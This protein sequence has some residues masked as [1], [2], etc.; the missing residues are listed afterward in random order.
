MSARAPRPTSPR[1]M[2]AL[3]GHLRLC[4]GRRR[5]QPAIA[6][7][8]QVIGHRPQNLGGQTASRDFCRRK[9]PRSTSRS[10][11]TLRSS[12]PST[13]ST[14]V[15]Q[16]E[17]PRRRALPTAGIQGDPPIA[18]TRTSRTSGV[19]SAAITGQL[20]VPHLSGWRGAP[21]PPVQRDAR[22]ATHR[23]DLARA[24]IR[25]AFVL[26]LGPSRR[27]ARPGHAAEAPS[28]RSSSRFPASSRSAESASGPPSTF[29]TPSR[30]C[31][32]RA[33][34]GQ[35]PVRARRRRLHAALR[36]RQARCEDPR[37][38]VDVYDPAEH[39]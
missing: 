15:L 26:R 12:P 25:Q 38:Q 22:P 2:P 14:F 20:T 34:P 27:G 6:T 16:R 28:R 30:T 7:Y 8:I 17:D 9:E 19:D 23:L 5:S 36:H 11:G 3:A 21:S 35:C 32:T 18:T 24:Q 4:P 29:S 1:P 13:I 37:P 39:Y 33:R 10:G 31:S